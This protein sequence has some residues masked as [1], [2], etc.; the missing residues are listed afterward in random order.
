MTCRETI[1]DG[2]VINFEFMSQTVV[3]IFFCLLTIAF[4][5]IFILLSKTIGN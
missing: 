2:S 4:V 5:A 1:G 3:F